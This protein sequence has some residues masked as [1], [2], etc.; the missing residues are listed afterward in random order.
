MRGFFMGGRHGAGLDAGALELLQA[1]QLGLA[2]IG[3]TLKASA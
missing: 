1:G 3:L 2:G